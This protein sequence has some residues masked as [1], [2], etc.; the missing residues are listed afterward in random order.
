[1]GYLA[2]HEGSISEARHI[3]LES[4]QNFQQDKVLIGTI[5]NLEGM[6]GLY[7]EVGKPACSARLIGWAD[8]ERKKIGN[9][10]PRIEKADVD[11][12]V[13]TCIAK[14]GEAT[15]SDEYDEGQTMTVD[16]AVAYALK[17]SL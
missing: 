8:S 17:E 13:A 7:V 15:F 5:F 11:K 3:F 12:I 4:A 1:M 14:L 6:A 2:L 9:A 10:R 16:E